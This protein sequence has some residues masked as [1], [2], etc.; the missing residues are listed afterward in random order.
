M[1]RPNKIRHRFVPMRIIDAKRIPMRAICITK[2]RDIWPKSRWTFVQTWHADEVESGKRSHT[3]WHIHS[4]KNTIY[5]L[6]WNWYN[7]TEGTVSCHNWANIGP[8]LG[9]QCQVS[10]LNQLLIE[11]TFNKN[12]WSV[13]TLINDL[14]L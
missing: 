7:I 6:H 11:I 5:L 2:G 13:T 1:H 8:R 3:Y 12:T 4:A 10:F 9:N 14:N